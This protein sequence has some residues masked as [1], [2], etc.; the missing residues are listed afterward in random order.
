MKKYFTK[1]LP[2]EDKIKENDKALNPGNGKVVTVNEACLKNLV[3]DDWKKV[4]LF[5]CDKDIQVG[6]KVNTILNNNFSKFKIP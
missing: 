2:V 6:D 4:K 3:D 5:L 1:Y